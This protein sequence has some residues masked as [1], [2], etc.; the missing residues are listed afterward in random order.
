MGNPW[1]S[2]DRGA[3]CFNAA[4]NWQLGWYDDNKLL[5]NPNSSPGTYTLVGIADFANNPAGH[6]VV[7]KLETGTSIDQFIAFNRAA[8]VNR[9]ND[10]ADDEVTIVETGQNGEWYSQSFLKAHLVTGQTYTYSSW[11]GSS[12]NTLTITAD[13]INLGTN[14]ATAT[15]TICL[16]DDCGVNEPSS[17]PSDSPSTSTSPT[18][19]PS[20]SPSLSSSPTVKHSDAPSLSNQPSSSPS[21]APSASNQPSSNPS[22]GPS[23]SV[24]PSIKHSA[25]PSESNQPSWSPSDSPSTSTSP[26]VN[27]N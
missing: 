22:S 26:T 14:P 27:I 19:N 10:E 24:A 15:I 16:N 13:E 9:D 1:Y 7:I 21:G 2:D 6:P 3:M 11:A 20:A 17:S 12:A 25:A 18:V 4:K 8:G 5:V 23:L